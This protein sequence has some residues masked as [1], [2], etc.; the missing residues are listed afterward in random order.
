MNLPA[1]QN[2]ATISWIEPVATDNSGQV[3]TR[4]RTHAPDSVFF[5]GAPTTVTYTFTDGS[6]NQATCSFNVQLTGKPMFN[7]VKLS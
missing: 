6:N 7:T 4:T 1:G 3:P 2:S 5:A